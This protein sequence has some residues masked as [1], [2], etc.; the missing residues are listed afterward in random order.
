MFTI[1]YFRIIIENL[2]TKDVQSHL[3]KLFHKKP[4][5]K[6]TCVILCL[7][8]LIF[9][10]CAKEEVK[11]SADSLLTTEAIDTINSLRK[12]YQEKNGSLLRDRSGPLVAEYITGEGEHKL[13]WRVG[14]SSQN[15]KESGDC[16]FSP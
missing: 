8:F 2:S 16:R 6:K 5:M 14:Y 4:S 12:A 11:P 1:H 9:P 15:S 7:L 10:G 13:A 3:F